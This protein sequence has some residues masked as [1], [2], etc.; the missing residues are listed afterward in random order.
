MVIVNEAFV[1]RYFPGEDPVGRRIGYGDPEHAKYWRTIVG[2]ARDT[3]ERIAAAPEPL[4]YA[5]AA[6]DREPWNAGSY[7]VKSSL[8]ATAVGERVRQAVLAVD[9]D[10]PVGRVRAIEDDMRAS[11]A[12]ERFTALLATLFAGLALVLAA[13]GT[14]G[15]MSHVVASRTRELGVR[16]ALG[17][18]RR[19]IVRLVVGQAARLVVVAVVV[20]LLAS[21]VLGGWLRTLLYEIVPGDPGALAAA[22]SILVA[23]ALAA[24][25]L[26]VRRALAADPMASLRR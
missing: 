6:Q 17:A 7:L 22:A 20:G 9:P 23:T 1:R 19:D 18:T 21:T 14:F 10:Q 2:I 24:S 3:R 26:P 25:Y 4:A 15:V 11:I 13:V 12:I 5:P 16:L 8:P